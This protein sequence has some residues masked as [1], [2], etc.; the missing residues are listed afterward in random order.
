MEDPYGWMEN[1]D[2]ERVTK[3]I[4]QANDEFKNYVGTLSS[5]LYDEVARYYNMPR[6]WGARL[7][8]N[9]TFVGINEAGC[10]K[11]VRLEDE[12]VFL[13]S[14]RLEKQMG[15]EILLQGFTMDDEGELLAYNFSIGGSDEG[16]TRI[17]RV[18]DDAVIEE[19]KPSVWNI[20]FLPDGYY[21]SRFYRREKTP[22]GMAPPAQR[23]FFKSREK[24]MV[25]GEGLDSNHFIHLKR[26]GDGKWALLTVSEGWNRSDI[27]FGPIGNPG[28]WKKVYTCDRPAEPIDVVEG[29]VYI[30]T[31]EGKGFGKIVAIGDSKTIVPEI[32]EPLEWAVI[33]KGKILAGYLHDASSKLV[34]YDINGKKE[35]VIKFDMLGYVI[36]LDHK[37]DVLL[38]FES[39]TVPYRLYKFDGSL[40]FM[41]ESSIQGNFAVD[42]DFA[43]SKDGTK[44]HYFKVHGENAKKIAWVFGYGGFNI[45]L[46]PRLFPQVLPFL[47]RGGT[48]VMANLRGGGEYGEEWHRAGMREN[49]QNVFDD[50]IAVLEKLKREGYRV[51]GWGRSNGGL[52]VSATLVQRPDVMDAAIIGYPVIDMM[53][54][55]RLY[56]GRVWIPEYGDPDNPEDREFLSKYS[57]YHNVRNNNYPPTLIYTGLHDDRVHPA[58]ALKFYMKLKK[59]GAPVYLRVETKSGHMGASPETRIKELADM[60]AFVIKNA[61]EELDRS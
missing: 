31:R 35:R 15:D 12:K 45:S 53:K 50:F 54:F 13:D 38:R 17:V 7:T 36:P 25:F 30:L 5:S 40:K 55:H 24:R 60:L 10:Q 34:L 8:K 49:K 47:L 11:I 28:K 48:F 19:L 6:I 41:K 44:I 52:L 43:I 46:T 27:Y 32:G 51:V 58:H 42:E 23:L 59:R 18:S 61:G 16:I 20:I 26:S 22:D 1:L 56:I 37:D 9:G 33:V 14:K 4:H 29:K 2:D 3:I 39:F 57:P 21:F